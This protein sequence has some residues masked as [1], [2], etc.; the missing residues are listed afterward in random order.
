MTNRSKT[1]EGE[2]DPYSNFF[3]ENE[4]PLHEL[5]NKTR[6]LPPYTIGRYWKLILWFPFGVVIGVIRFVAFF[7]LGMPLLTIFNLFDAEQFLFYCVSG[8][9]K[10]KAFLEYS[11]TLFLFLLLRYE[12]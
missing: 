7:V 3:H 11:W 5:F 9:Y 4:P 10:F 1:S 6:F 12:P 8:N 2:N